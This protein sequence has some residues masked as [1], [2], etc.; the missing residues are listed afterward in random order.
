[1]GAKKMNRRDFLINSMITGGGLFLTKSAEAAVLSESVTRGK[2][3]STNE[4]VKLPQIGFGTMALGASTSKCVSEAVE[5]GYRLF[6]TARDYGTE[7]EVFQ[8][9][10]DS[11]INRKEVF[12]TTKIGPADMRNG[13]QRGAIEKSIELLG[14]DYIDLFLIHWPV[15]DKIQK[16]W[17]ILEEY[18]GA[19]KIKYLG[20]SNFNPHHI[21]NLMSYARVKPIVNQLEINPYFANFGLAE[22]SKAIGITAE[23]WSPLRQAKALDDETLG[24]LAKKYGKSPAQIIL[25]WEIHRGL[26]AIPRSSKKEHMAEN[27]NIFDFE[28]TPEDMQSVNALNRDERNNPRNNPD[29]F[30]W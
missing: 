3:S 15:V 11:G 5:L 19:G 23:C 25:R 17:R 18:V 20:L 8:G 24:S 13:V 27:I 12:I 1:M 10:K 28:L 9:I 29:R 4:Q 6:D 22:Y 30:P 14:Y 21:Q 7:R 16:T 26:V 2:Y